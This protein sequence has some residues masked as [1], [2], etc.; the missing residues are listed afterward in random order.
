[1]MAWQGWSSVLHTHVAG[2]RVLWC[3][4]ASKMAVIRG[5]LQGWVGG[6]VA[7]GVAAGGVGVRHEGR[8]PACM[9]TGTE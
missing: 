7:G 2:H 9:R 3:D 1:M 6:G 5:I 4:R 8:G